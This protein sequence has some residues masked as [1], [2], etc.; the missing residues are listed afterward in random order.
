MKKIFSIC[1]MFSVILFGACTDVD[2]AGETPE[3]P[4]TPEEP[5]VAPE[6]PVVPAGFDWS[7]ET[8]VNLTLESGVTTNVS[9]Y[10]EE[11][12]QDNSLLLEDVL[13]ESDVARTFRMAVPAGAEKLY[14]KYPA[15][16]GA[17]DVVALAVNGADVNYNSRS[18]P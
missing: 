18:T 15:A 13:L 4:G 1:A 10:S 11:D 7:T 8:G 9:V 17:D 14:V 12:C 3:V 2:T 5:V 16:S 6:I